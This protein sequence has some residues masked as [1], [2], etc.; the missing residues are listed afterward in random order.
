M[1]ISIPVDNVKKYALRKIFYC[2][3]IFLLFPAFLLNAWR[4]LPGHYGYH[5]LGFVVLVVLFYFSAEGCASDKKINDDFM[6]KVHGGIVFAFSITAFLYF[7][8]LFFTHG[9]GFEYF[10]SWVAWTLR[11]II[12]VV[13]IGLIFIFGFMPP[14]KSL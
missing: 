7:I 13:I 14:R 3:G 9:P 4:I 6:D 1:E 11:I 12:Q 8:S 5:Y 2:M 10:P